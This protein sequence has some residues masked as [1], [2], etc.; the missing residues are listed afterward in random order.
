VLCQS[1]QSVDS[2]D[3]V[4]VVTREALMA[5][6]EVVPV[7]LTT[8]TTHTKANIVVTMVTLLRV[9]EEEEQ[10]DAT[11][12]EETHTE[13]RQTVQQ[14]G[15]LDAI[16]TE[17]DAVESTYTDV[18]QHTYFLGA[19][20][21]NVGHV[22]AWY[23]EIDICGENCRFKIDTG[24]DIS[25]MSHSQYDKLH[26]APPLTP[27]KAVLKSPGGVLKTAG[28]FTAQAKL[29]GTDDSMSLQ[30]V[31]VD[32]DMDNLLSRSASRQ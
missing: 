23:A 9:E 19:V 13:K 5:T 32:G 3:T 20:D 27:T 11:D 15:K 31:V 6:P 1:T 4:V 18:E 25:I 16:L 14:K 7:T 30:V 26:L 28:Q 10:G 8:H 2:V 12:A 21:D 17:T 24:A 22:P 29:H